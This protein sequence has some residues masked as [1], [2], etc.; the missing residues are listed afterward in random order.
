[1]KELL[2]KLQRKAGSGLRLGFAACR[3]HRAKLCKPKICLHHPLERPYSY[4]EVELVVGKS[5]MLGMFEVEIDG[6]SARSSCSL[7]GL[8]ACEAASQKLEC[9]DLGLQVRLQCE[10]DSHSFHIHR[11]LKDC[12]PEPS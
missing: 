9:F 1:M 11:I 5:N 2:V 3:K 7:L 4:C 8:R 6:I 10:P 12:I